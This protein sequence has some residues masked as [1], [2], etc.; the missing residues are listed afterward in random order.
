MLTNNLESV[1]PEP[2]SKFPS[3]VDCKLSAEYKRK[4]SPFL[5]E[6]YIAN[7][8]GSKPRTIRTK[9]AITFIIE[10]SSCSES[11]AMIVLDKIQN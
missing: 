3:H 5:L 11:I 4:L 8:T 7:H 6:K 9:D 1:H 2:K 10:V